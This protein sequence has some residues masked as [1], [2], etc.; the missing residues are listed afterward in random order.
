MRAGDA[1]HD[2]GIAIA[3]MSSRFRDARARSI[4]LQGDFLMAVR[5]NPSPKKNSRAAAEALAKETKRPVEEVQ[6]LYE[7]ELNDLANEAKVTQY[8]GVLAS[9]RVKMRLR[10]H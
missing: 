4:A 6:K 8:L 2:I 1:R 3:A 10:K 5:T 7:E 9:R